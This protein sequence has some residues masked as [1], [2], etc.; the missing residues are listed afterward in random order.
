VSAARK[1]SRKSEKNRVRDA[2]GGQ[3]EGKKDGF[4]LDP[5][6]IVLVNDR[7]SA[8]DDDRARGKY[9]ESLVLN[10][11]A[12]GVHTPIS[13]R[14]NT[15][16]GEI[17]CVAGRRRVLANREANKRLRARGSEPRWIPAVVKKGDASDMM[18]ILVSE[19]AQRLEDS[20][21][22]RARKMQRHLDLGRSEE[23]VAL[24]N[25]CSVATLRNIVGLLELP[26]EA[27]CAVED[28]KVDASA[29]YK[30][31]GKDPEEVKELVKKLATKAPVGEGRKRRSGAAASA[32]REIVDGTPGMRRKKEIEQKLGEMEC[33]AKPGAKLAA[34][35]LRWVLG[36][37]EALEEAL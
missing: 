32:A 2:L 30:M 6:K 35:A 27:Q 17:E 28:R 14:K 34:A 12:I 1:R 7:G 33:L 10:I 18:D 15:E 8:L 21:M 36:G 22:N 9:S 37:K 24:M 13:V 25:D 3:H 11:M 4:L 29:M 5:D 31:R 20:P 23:H 19:N 16:T 26:K